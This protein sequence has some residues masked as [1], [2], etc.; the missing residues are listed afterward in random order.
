M[1]VDPGFHR[2]WFPRSNLKRGRMLSSFAF[3]FNLRPG[4]EAC[5]NMIRHSGDD[6]HD[7]YRI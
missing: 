4:T 7:F 1:H 5:R 2:V 6:Y 3:N